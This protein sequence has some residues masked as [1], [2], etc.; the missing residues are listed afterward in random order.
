ML[1]GQDSALARE[2]DDAD[3]QEQAGT[4]DDVELAIVATLLGHELATVCSDQRALDLDGLRERQIAVR[5][6]LNV[7]AAEDALISI[8]QTSPLGV[9][10]TNTIE[11]GNQDHRVQPS[12]DTVRPWA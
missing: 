7:L 1:N 2:G 8:W 9:R 3:Q 12:A 5:K 4:T 11:S 6:P 10:F